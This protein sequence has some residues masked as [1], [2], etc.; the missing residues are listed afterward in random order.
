MV[1]R[2]P[3]RITR[4]NKFDWESVVE[5]VEDQSVVIGVDVAKE[6]MVA[7]VMDEGEAILKTVGWSHPT[8]TLEFIAFLEALRGGGAAS[9]LVAM[10]PSGVYG[11]ALRWQLLLAGFEVSRVSPKK[12]SDSAEIYD[13]VRSSH[14]AKSAAIVAWLH[15]H[16]KSEP[17]PVKSDHE[18]ALKAALWVLEVH[19]KQFRQNRNRLEAMTARYWPELTLQLDLDSATLLEL[20]M[21]FGGPAEV[22]ARSTDARALMR[23]VGGS[24]LKAEK[25]AAVLRSASAT[26]GMPQIDEEIRLVKAI[27]TEARRNQHEERSARRQV[28]KLAG[29]E[30]STRHMQPVIGKTT[31]AVVVAAA[32]DPLN[33]ESPQALVKSLGLN[34]R[35]KSSGKKQS[36][37]HITKR[38]SGTARMFLYMAALRLIKDDPVV[39]A[40]YAKK[41]ARD[42]GKAKIKAVVAVTR[43]LVLALW[44]VARGDDFDAAKLFDTRRLSIPSAP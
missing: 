26:T 37:L 23:R 13:G 24:M 39:K 9:V 31:A 12:S 1:K 35:E 28:E 14:D 2:K 36:A 8:Q 15:F 30:G 32:G 17:W 5:D 41:V 18:R 21:E 43:K 4:V 7:V 20:L 25:I 29:S 3:Y 27:A 38:G 42:G 22:A 10:E 44:H 19:A 34:L 16:G 6:K 33:Y 40:W 11:D